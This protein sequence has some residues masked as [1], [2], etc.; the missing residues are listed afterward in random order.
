M[1][2]AISR[3]IQYIPT[4]LAVIVFRHTKKD[5]ARPFKVPLGPVIPVIA[6]LI[7]GW[8]LFNTPSANLIWGFGA[9]IIA[10]P[11]YFLTGRHADENFS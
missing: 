4:C 3:F 2:S 5:V 11:F 9:L 8:L 1:I 6:L 10:I 7:S